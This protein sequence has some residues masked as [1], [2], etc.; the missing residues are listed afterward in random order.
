MDSEK[1]CLQGSVHCGGSTWTWEKRHY[2]LK[3]AWEQCNLQQESHYLC[4]SK[5]IY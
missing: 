5:S 4:D 2:P 3:V 1:A